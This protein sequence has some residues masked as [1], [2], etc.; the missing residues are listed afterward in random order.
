METV[1]P[2]ETRPVTFT[3]LPSGLVG[4][5]GV[6][7]EDSEDGILQARTTAG[8]TEFAAGNYRKLITFPEE[9][10][11]VYVVADDEGVEAI[12]EFRITAT[13][14]APT[15][16]RPTVAQVAAILRARTYAEGS[17]EVDAGEEVGTFDNTTRP[18]SDQV[19]ELIDL[20]VADVSMRVGVD[21]P[22]ALRASAQ[23]VA[24]LRAASEIER[25]YL[26]EQT[27]SGQSIYQT[28][29]LTYDEEVE[30]LA[31]TMQWWVLAHRLEVA[32][33]V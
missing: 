2:G 5:L 22:E 16:W 33:E 32:A 25:S 8:F 3:N 23:R 18:T 28:L 21:I 20:A 15:D 30:K 26:P 12:E 7:L 1:A 29:R 11:W 9:A 31:Q 13:P 4:T 17:D 14:D 19:E 6:R 27:D 10:G 24:A